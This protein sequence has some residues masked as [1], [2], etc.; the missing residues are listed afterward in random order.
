MPDTYAPNLNSCYN[1]QSYRSVTAHVHTV[2]VLHE[3]WQVSLQDGGGATDSCQL[4]DPL[5]HPNRPGGPYTGASLNPARTIGPAVVFTCNVGVSFLYIF[6]E[7]FGAAC[8]AGLSI[9]LYGRAPDSVRR[10]AI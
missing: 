1:A 4:C 8:A 6:A 9:F 3:S 7:F 2:T 10:P 5:C